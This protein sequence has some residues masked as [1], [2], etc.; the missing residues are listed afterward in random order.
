MFTLSL[1]LSFGASKKQHC[2]FKLKFGTETNLSIENSMVMLTLPGLDWES[3][4]GQIWFKKIKKIVHLRR[5][6]LLK[7]TGI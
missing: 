4:A 1:L 2:Q 7:L 3:I 6:L 5:N